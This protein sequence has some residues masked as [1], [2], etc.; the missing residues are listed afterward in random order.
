M[1]KLRQRLLSMQDRKYQNFHS[2]LCPGITNIIGIRIPVLRQLA[3]EISHGDAGR[4]YLLKA[5][6]EPFRYSE[7]ATLCG[8]VLGLMKI[9]FAELLNY[10]ELFVP[11]IDSWS[12]CDVTCVGLKVFKKNKEQG[13]KFLQQ[14][15]NSSHEY[16]LR[17]AIVMLLSYYHDDDYIDDTLC[18]LNAVRHEG[19]YVKM[20]VAWA[21]QLCF[22]KQREKTLLLLQKNTL[23]NFTYNKALQKCHESFRV[24]AGDKTL[25]QSMKRQ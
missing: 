1:E 8:M 18:E 13:R 19:Y 3:M 11:R 14:Y 22:V 2:V 7:E 6:R 4:A 5:L 25:L 20:A 23:D 15:L 12:I 10:L 9:D 21:L 17:F 16:E 24:T